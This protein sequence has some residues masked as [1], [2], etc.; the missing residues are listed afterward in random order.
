V[1]HRRA[2]SPAEERR[3]GAERRSGLEWRSGAERRSAP[4]RPVQVAYDTGPVT[5]EHGPAVTDRRTGL[6][7]RGYFNATI[8]REIAR[9]QRFGGRLSLVLLEVESLETVA[10]ALQNNLRRVDIAAPHG[11]DL[12]AI[13]LGDTDVHAACAVAERLCARAGAGACAGVAEFPLAAPSTS[14]DELIKAA[15]RALRL[16]KDGGAP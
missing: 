2:L 8:R 11:M 1:L 5:A 7:T 10:S 3:S 9:C 12:V 15:A 13:I 14:E 16:A 4:S 6:F